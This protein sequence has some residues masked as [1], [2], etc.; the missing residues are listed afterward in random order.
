M[1]CPCCK[2]KYSYIDVILDDGT[3]SEELCGFC[4]QGEVNL[5]K[6]I[7]WKFNETFIWRKY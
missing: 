3:G 1:R 2:G 7:Y 4:N 5:F 6:W